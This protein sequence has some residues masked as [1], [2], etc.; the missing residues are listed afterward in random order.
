ME[1]RERKGLPHDKIIAARWIPDP[2]NSRVFFKD[3]RESFY[4]FHVE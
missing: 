4:F 2:S 1:G 3:I